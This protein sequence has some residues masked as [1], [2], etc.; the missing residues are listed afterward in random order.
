MRESVSAP[1]HNTF[2]YRPDFTNAVETSS[3]YRNPLHAAERSNAGVEPMPN[4]AATKQPVD[5]NAIAG[6]AVPTTTR[7]MSF[8][9]SP[10]AFIARV[11]AWL[12]S[13]AVDS[14]ELAPRRSLIPV[15][16]M[17]HSSLV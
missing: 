7:S 11:A 17:I 16:W 2:L 6:V 14:V 12:A 8:A 3:A 10:A 13:V 1:M 15:R 4:D 5:G 9:S